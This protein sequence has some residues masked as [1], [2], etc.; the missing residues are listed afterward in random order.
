MK[1]V[2]DDIFDYQFFN[3]DVYELKYRVPFY[4]ITSVEN[5]KFSA[6]KTQ[7]NLLLSRFLANDKFLEINRYIREQKDGNDSSMDNLIW[8]FDNFILQSPVLDYEMILYRGIPC[9]LN[10][11]V[12]DMLSNMGFI[13]CSLERDIARYFLSDTSDC[14]KYPEQSDLYV[15]KADKG[16][17]FTIMVPKSVHFLDLSFYDTSYGQD[18]VYSQILLP[19][20]TSFIVSKVDTI[21]NIKY[22]TMTVIS[23]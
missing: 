3:V 20:S 22:V 8:S 7:N 16:T 5:I 4:N 19:A 9:D 10:I 21:D 15:K 23:S 6:P 13:F 11:Q 18:R 14:Y 2:T 12:G 17:L 1:S